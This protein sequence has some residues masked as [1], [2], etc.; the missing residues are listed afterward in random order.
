M[1]QAEL[2]ALVDRLRGLPNETEWLE[3]KHN[4][5]DAQEIGE[6]LAALAN[7]AALLHQPGAI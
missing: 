2:V 6:Y 1:N 5:A 3:F 4:N 7:E